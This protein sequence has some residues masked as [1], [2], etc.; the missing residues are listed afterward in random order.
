[1]REMKQHTREELAEAVMKYEEELWPRG[2]EAVIASKENTNMLHDWESLWKS[3][4][5]VAGVAKDAKKD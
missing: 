5:F 2:N 3:P 1:V 4:L